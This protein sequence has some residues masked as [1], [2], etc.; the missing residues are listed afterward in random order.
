MTRRTLELV[1]IL[2][3]YNGACEENSLVL[4]KNQVVKVTAK[5][6]DGWCFGVSEGDWGWFPASYCKMNVNLVKT[7]TEEL[8][9]VAEILESKE[10]RVYWIDEEQLFFVN[11]RTKETTTIPPKLI[12]NQKTEFIFTSPTNNNANSKESTKKAVRFSR[13]KRKIAS[14]K[15][16]IQKSNPQITHYMEPSPPECDQR[17]FA[18]S[19]ILNSFPPSNSSSQIQYY[20]QFSEHPSKNSK[21]DHL[22]LPRSPVSPVFQSKFG[23]LFRINQLETFND[24]RNAQYSIENISKNTQ[25]KNNSRPKFRNISDAINKKFRGLKSQSYYDTTTQIEARPDISIDNNVNDSLE[26]TGEFWEQGLFFPSK[27]N[28]K[29]KQSKFENHF[30]TSKNSESTGLK[31]LE[32][33]YASKMDQMEKI[34][35]FFSLRAKAEREYACKLERI[36]EI[37][38]DLPEPSTLN[39][40]LLDIMTQNKISA[41]THR[42]F[43]DNIAK[44]FYDPLDTF[45][46]NN[47]YNIRNQYIDSQRIQHLRLKELADQILPLQNE[48]INAN[49]LRNCLAD[50]GKGSTQ[51]MADMEKLYAISREVKSV[52]SAQYIQEYNKILE[53]FKVIHIEACRLMENIENERTNL[54]KTTMLDYCAYQKTALE[55]MTQQIFKCKKSLDTVNINVDRVNLI[56]TLGS[57]RKTPIR[58]T[59]QWTSQ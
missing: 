9:R 14:I 2:F 35:R 52:Q 43:A 24:V 31:K 39:S 33:N 55:D 27:I 11:K 10:W 28:F 19:P 32:Q 8:L 41:N 6:E 12:P 26:R 54:L 47:N 59:E 49:V 18:R 53:C 40:A 30:W 22:D 44:N 29:D 46:R 16:P 57:P 58:V 45:L 21:N 13:L 37:N 51:S 56:K 50:R 34:T 23:P 3:E 4:A 5:T 48:T 42:N 25:N 38:I 15:N 36:G 7:S 17:R 20:A 1:T